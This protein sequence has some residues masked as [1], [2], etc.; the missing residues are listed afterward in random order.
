MNN[1]II[2]INGEYLNF[3]RENLSELC[4]EKKLDLDFNGNHKIQIDINYKITN[5]MNGWGENCFE[6]L[7]TCKVKFYKEIDSSEIEF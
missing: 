5:A 4:R 6:E 3:S 7:K 1:Y 2:E